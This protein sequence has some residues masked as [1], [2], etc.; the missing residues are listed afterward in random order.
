MSEKDYMIE[1]MVRDIVLLL[2][3]RKNMDMECALNTLYNSD[4]Y[5]KLQDEKTG[6]YFQSPRYVYSFLENELTT[7]RFS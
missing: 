6:L 5:L 7:G 4:T 1:C 3:N 2:M